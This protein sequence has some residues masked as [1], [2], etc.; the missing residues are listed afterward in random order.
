[1]RALS[2][3]RTATYNIDKAYLAHELIRETFLPN[4]LVCGHFETGSN[5]YTSHFEAAADVR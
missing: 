2:K 4:E 1:M 3:L 5:L